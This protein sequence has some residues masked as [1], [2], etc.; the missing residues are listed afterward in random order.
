MTKPAKPFQLAAA[1]KS[2][3]QAVTKT[4]TKQRKAEERASNAVSNRYVRLVYERGMFL[5]EAAFD[6]MEGA[7]LAASDG[8][9]LPVKARQIMYAAR[10]QILK[11]TDKDSLNDA[12]FTQ[13]LLPDYMEENDCEDWDVIWDARGNFAEPYT[14]RTVP[15]GTLEVRQYLDIRPE[16]GAVR[17]EGEADVDIADNS[18]FPTKGPKNR[19]DTVLFVE[20]EGFGP[21]L[22]AARI[23]ERYDLAVM[24][25]KGMSTTSARML[26]DRLVERGV[27]RVLVLHDFDISGFSIFG[28]LFTDSRRYSFQNKVPAVDL[29]LRLCDVEA[30]GL[31]SEPFVIETWNA[32]Q[33][34]NHAKA[35]R[36]D[37]CG[38]RV[39]NGAG[40]HPRA[41]GR[42]Q[43]HDRPPVSRF[44]RAEIQRARRR[45]GDPGC[46]C[47]Q[48]ACASSD[49]TAACR[50]S[51]RGNHG[52]DRRGGGGDR[53]AGGSP[54]SGQGQSRSR[55][56]AVLGRGGRGCRRGSAV[57]SARRASPLQFV[58]NDVSRRR[59]SAC[60]IPDG[61][62]L[63]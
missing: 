55:S 59:D 2:S 45:E 22:Q 9:K 15:I 23:A 36:R 7:Y 29:G 39:L 21:L 13:T 46:W 63:S 27:K 8:G 61:G 62:E 56:D 40:I 52:A 5:R 41:T 44:P 18:R 10:P 47:A 57:M 31:Q 25:T 37:G 30:M 17:G 43:C 58:K 50:G 20:K 3:T 42:A 24:S 53:V 4:W 14:K 1:I 32:K 34:K 28:T 16:F 38:D 11:L 33:K 54:G 35:S 19:Y 49:R 12:Y 6:V 48:A 60:S 26:L 51:D